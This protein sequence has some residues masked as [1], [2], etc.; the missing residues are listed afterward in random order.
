MN[1]IAEFDWRAIEARLD[2]EGQAVP[3]GVLSAAECD[4]L[5]AL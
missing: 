5:V 4:S 1:S 2:L 3:R